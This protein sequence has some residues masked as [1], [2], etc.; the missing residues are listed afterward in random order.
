[1]NADESDSSEEFQKI[2]DLLKSLPTIPV[3]MP[4]AAPSGIYATVSTAA[5]SVMGWLRTQQDVELRS[6]AEGVFSNPTKNVVFPASPVRPKESSVHILL[7]ELSA[8]D[9]PDVDKS[10]SD[11]DEPIFRAQSDALMSADSIATITSVSSISSSK[12]PTADEPSE[13]VRQL[14]I[15]EESHSHGGEDGSSPLGRDISCSQDS[16]SSSTSAQWDVVP[17]STNHH[18][19]ERALLW[20]L[21]PAIYGI[22]SIGV[23]SASDRA[24]RLIAACQGD[25]N[26]AVVMAAGG[27]TGG[28]KRSRI[29]SDFLIRQVPFVGCPAYI[30]TST[31]THLRAIATIAAIYGHDVQLARTQHEI[32]FCLIPQ[33]GEQKFDDAPLG[34]TAKSVASMLV[35]SAI[36]KS[37][38]ITL[39][40]ELFQLG[41]DLW[42]TKTESESDFECLSLGPS[43]TAR[44][45]FC[46]DNSFNRTRLVLIAVAGILV[47]YLYRFPSLLILILVGFLIRKKISVPILF[48]IFLSY[49][50]FSLHAFLPVIGIV[51]GLNLLVQATFAEQWSFGSISIFILGLMALTGSLKNFQ[52]CE[53]VHFEVRKIAIGIAFFAHFLPLC[54]RSGIYMYRLGIELDVSKSLH[55]IS[56]IASSTFQ[57]MLFSELKRREVV[58]SLL[59]AERVMILSLTLFFRGVSAAIHPESVLLFFKK[60]TPHPLFCCLLMTVRSYTVYF[61]LLIAL[62]RIFPIW[63]SSSLSMLFGLFIGIILISVLWNNWQI[64]QNVYLSHMRLLHILP[65]TIPDKAK[66]IVD[67]LILSS[68]KSALKSAIFEIAKK[69][70]AKFFL[71]KVD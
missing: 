38:G 22:R 58:L 10:V 71:R 32:L 62:T 1:M 64:N 14:S 51:N 31:W 59:G 67:N 33:N 3:S 39:V 42:S 27:E 29:I 50:L 55:Y 52:I 15:S 60:I 53:T 68:G 8:H 66:S 49:S 35:T 47:P 21:T 65:G 63:T 9:E 16:P 26:A 7:N 44:H 48:P 11:A 18:A 30:L 5:T 19:V 37:T 43:A 41:T 12:D 70:M 36:S 69:I 54:D 20:C 45:Y 4:I 57:Q 23:I 6:H 61:A 2:E 24:S 34:T 25:T 46:P 40:S 17:Q 28:S 13:I 56:V